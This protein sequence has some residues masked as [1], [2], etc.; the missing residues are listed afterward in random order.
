[1]RAVRLARPPNKL[2][3]RITHEDGNSKLYFGDFLLSPWFQ[4]AH[5]SLKAIV[6]EQVTKPKITWRTYIDP[7][8][9]FED[10]EMAFSLIIKG[11]C[12]EC[13]LYKV[14]PSWMNPVIVE[15]VLTIKALSGCLRFDLTNAWQRNLI[16]ELFD[17]CGFQ[18]LT[19]LAEIRAKF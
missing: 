5:P 18:R 11:N 7:Y 15:N 19:D 17:K 2:S 3:F 4:H 6:S 9:D 12:Y 14:Y 13:E 8:S 10:N 1:M 16:L